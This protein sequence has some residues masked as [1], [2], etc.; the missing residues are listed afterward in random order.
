MDARDVPYD[1]HLFAVPLGST[2][3]SNTGQKAAIGREG[4]ALERCDRH[5]E[6]LEAPGVVVIPNS[7][8]RI[9]AFLRRCNQVTTLR[10]IEAADWCGVAEEEPRLLLSL[11]IHGY[12]GAAGGEEDDLLISNARPLQVQALVR[13]VSNDVLKLH[14]RVL[15]KLRV[16]LSLLTNEHTCLVR[17]GYIAVRAR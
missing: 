11:D 17:V 12:Q 4:D 1:N 10:D 13:R 15:M 9:L 8:D 3:L 14:N 5:S 2:F 16:H 6:H 7:Y